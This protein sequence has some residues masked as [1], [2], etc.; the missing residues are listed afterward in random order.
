M[1]PGA[2]TLDVTLCRAPSSATDLANPITPILLVEYA[3]WPKP[4][5]SP[6]IE[7][8]QITRPHLR[9]RMPGNTALV[10]LYVPVRLIVRFRSQS[11]SPMSLS[12]PIV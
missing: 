10:T 1:M 12:W 8:M 6:A 11:S 4:P 7:A 2:I 3:A 9:S 5:I